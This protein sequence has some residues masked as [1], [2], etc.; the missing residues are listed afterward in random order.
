MAKPIK[1]AEQA[2][3]VAAN[4]IWTVFDTLNQINQNPGFTPKWSDKP[5]LKSYEKMKPKL[6]W[7]RTT[8]SLCPKC[9]PEVR[10]QIL[11]GKQDVSILV[12]E[13]PGRDQGTDHRAGR[14]DP[15]GEGV[16][17]STAS[18]KT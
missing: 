11:D 4:G 5:L 3:A 8:D 2:L 9:I 16:P 7:P 17:E 13:Q 6:G 14:Q 1:Y 10:Q 18:L 15:D 12:N